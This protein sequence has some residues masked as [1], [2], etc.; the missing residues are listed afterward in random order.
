M[1]NVN[2]NEVEMSGI[3]HNVEFSHEKHGEKYYKGF[4]TIER[5]SKAEDTLP[6]MINSKLLPEFPNMKYVV[7][8][9]GQLRS[10][11]EI[12][13]GKSKLILYIFVKDI[14]E[15]EEPF[16]YEN[17]VKIEGFLCKNPVLR[18]SLSGLTICDLLVAV[19]NGKHT[20]YIPG[21][22]FKDNAEAITNKFKVGDK[23]DLIGRFQ[24]RL[25]QKRYTNEQLGE[26]V[27]TT[28]TAYELAV[29]WFSNEFTDIDFK[30]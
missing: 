8:I 16:D 5:N 21:I 3:L 10:R 24:S 25:Y 11:N 9:K 19:N 12:V 4:I 18:T 6:I 22:A 20:Y 2:L 27:I 17:E 23:I 30:I 29:Q 26:S 15:L 28:H 14:V 1:E 13:D 7:N